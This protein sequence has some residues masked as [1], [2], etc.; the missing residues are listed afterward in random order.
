MNYEP[1]PASVHSHPL[2]QWYVDAKFGIF[3]HWGLF[4]VPAYAPTR[5][6]DIQQL[7]QTRSQAEVFARQ[8]Y[9]E[10][11]QNSLRIQ[12]SPVQT[13]H[14]RTYGAEYPYERFA[15]EFNHQAQAWNP[16][17]WADLFA[18]C[19]A[20]YVV[21]VTK[22]HDGFTL[23]PSRH[24]NP[25]CPDFHARRDLVG[26]LARAVRSRGLRFGVYYSSALDWTFTSKPIRSFG[27]LMTSGPVTHEYR[28]YVWDHWH[29]LI[30]RVQ[31]DLL[32][33]DIGYPSGVKLA[34]LFAAYYN[35]LPE[36]VVN[37]RWTQ[38]PNMLRNPPGRWVIN[39]MVKAALKKGT[40]DQ[41]QVPHS[42][43]RTTEYTGMPEITSYKWEACRGIGNSFGYNRVET[44]SDYLKPIDLLPNLADIVS[45]NGNLLLNVGPCADGSIHPAQVKALAG[46]GSW[47]RDNGMALFGT[48]PWQKYKDTVA[49]GVD[50]R[51]TCHNEALYAVLMT[52]AGEEPL[53]FPGLSLPTGACVDLLDSGERLAFQPETDGLRVT[54]P[55]SA[56]QVPLKV[57]R[58]LP[59]K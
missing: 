23:W 20:G 47:L 39:R 6:G 45:K 37:D 48:H 31:P 41:L 36:G 22:H 14:A 26:E 4:S 43:F 5:E 57:I 2:P 10:W 16:D 58:F 1:T 33:S 21:L 12:G 19:G 34:E 27:D 53:L 7:F 13:Y 50:V 9:A 15:D 59:L 49:P 54:L 25:R 11:Y 28:R 46:M 32:W 55:A 29:E 52:P 18:R 44:E 56:Q 42:D 40:M 8:P 38:T 30:E 35:T 24:P 3:I 51:Y 17:E